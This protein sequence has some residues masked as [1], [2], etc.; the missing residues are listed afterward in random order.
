M[1]R[2]KIS[3]VMFFLICATALAAFAAGQKMMSVQVNTGVLRV[4][5]SFL[6][7][8][9]TR[10]SYG[11]RVYVLE[12]EESWTRVGLSWNAD[13]GWIHSS[14]LT[15]KKIVL[16]AGTEDVE[17]AASGEEIALAG[18]GFNQQVESEF[19]AENPNLDFTWIDR[20]EKCVVSERQMKRFLKE[21]GLSC[22]GGC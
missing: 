22:E 18:K 17:V 3:I 11:D 10:L 13:K 16:K 2:Q 6:G 20:M 8:I 4:T 7:G 15:P 12:E 1:I 19:R 9:V 14:A 21:G 5:P